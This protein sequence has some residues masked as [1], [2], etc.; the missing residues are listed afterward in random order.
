MDVFDPFLLYI[1][2]VFQI[3]FSVLQKFLL[4]CCIERERQ[5]QKQNT[6]F[7]QKVLLRHREF[8][9]S[10]VFMSRRKCY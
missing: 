8:D 6:V 10:V 7:E 3:V 4:V 9:N 5:L 1:L 2:V